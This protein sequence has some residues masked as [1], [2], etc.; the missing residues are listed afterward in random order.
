M[1]QAPTRYRALL[2]D[3]AVTLKG[4]AASRDTQAM[5]PDQIMEEERADRLILS[6]D[7]FLSYP[8]WVL[9]GK[10]LYPAATKRIHAFTQIFP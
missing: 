1:V 6:W 5:V 10:S 9:R 8:Q 2:R 3:T 4:R 7:N